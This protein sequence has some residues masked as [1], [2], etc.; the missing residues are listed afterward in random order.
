MVMKLFVGMITNR[1]NSNLRTVLLDK[2]S[3]YN[4]CSLVA[5][6]AEDYPA[7]PVRVLVEVPAYLGSPSSFAPT[8]IQGMWDAKGWQ[9]STV[10]NQVKPRKHVQ[11]RYSD[12]TV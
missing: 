7:L 1:L 6:G 8:E 10:I 9:P 5:F 4:R 2:P 3:R 11:A 12:R